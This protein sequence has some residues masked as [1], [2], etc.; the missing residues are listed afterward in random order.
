[1]ITRCLACRGGGDT[2]FCATCGGSGHVDSDARPGT[3]DDTRLRDEVAREVYAALLG[4]IGY[5]D[6]DY[7]QPP[8]LAAMAF[9]A[10][11]AWMAERT[12]RIT[13]GKT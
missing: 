6:H 7:A 12:K 4:S 1:M 9:D 13:E 10:A 2:P 3:D 8:E 5:P 11:D